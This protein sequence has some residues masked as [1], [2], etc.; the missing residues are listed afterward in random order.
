MDVSILTL[1]KQVDHVADVKRIRELLR[2]V[3]PILD[4]EGSRGCLLWP[5]LRPLSPT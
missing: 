1:D 3:Y 5:L 4:G 2:R